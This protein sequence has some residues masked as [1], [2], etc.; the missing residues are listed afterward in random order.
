[1]LFRS[2]QTNIYDVGMIATENTEQYKLVYTQTRLKI[3]AAK[4]NM[5]LRVESWENCDP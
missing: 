4:E 3:Q 1:M 5:S 2:D